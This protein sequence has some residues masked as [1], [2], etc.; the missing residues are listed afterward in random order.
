MHSS[1][2]ATPAK[3][4]PKF[5]EP[6]R[7]QKSSSIGTYSHNNASDTKS[8]EPPKHQILSTGTYYKYNSDTKPQI[9]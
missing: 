9:Q 3:A 4:E 6:L 8:T 7:Y 1:F 5:Q 2:M